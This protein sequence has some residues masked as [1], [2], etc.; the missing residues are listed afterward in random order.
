MKKKKREKRETENTR[1]RKRRVE[2]REGSMVRGFAAQSYVISF[3]EFLH[4]LHF[5]CDFIEI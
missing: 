1:R 4:L 5:Y 3:G 2:S